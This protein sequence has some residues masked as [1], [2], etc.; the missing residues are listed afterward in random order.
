LLL[1]LSELTNITQSKWTKKGT[2]P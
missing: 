2:Q 1:A